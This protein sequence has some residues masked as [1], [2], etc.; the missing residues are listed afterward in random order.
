MKAT[1]PAV[2]SPCDCVME[3]KKGLANVTSRHAG[4]WPRDAVTEDQGWQRQENREAREEEHTAED[5]PGRL[6]TSPQ[7]SMLTAIAHEA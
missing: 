7:D 1:S 5:R 4:R 2:C 6:R 3:G